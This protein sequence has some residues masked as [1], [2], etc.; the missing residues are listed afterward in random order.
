MIEQSREIIA[1]FSGKPH[2][3]DAAVSANPY[4]AAAHHMCTKFDISQR[5]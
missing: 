5:A 3:G 1:Y 4:N 2:V